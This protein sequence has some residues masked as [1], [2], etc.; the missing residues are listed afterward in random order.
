MYL[1]Q[2]LRIQRVDFVHIWYNN[3]VKQVADAFKIALCSIQN[4]SNYG[5]IFLKLYVFVA[6]SQNTTG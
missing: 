2:Y 3:Q 6:I 4:L 5:N 1:L